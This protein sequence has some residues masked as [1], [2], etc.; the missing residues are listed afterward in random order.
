MSSLAIRQREAAEGVTAPVDILG[1]VAH[2]L[3]QPLSNIE[4]IAYY[5]TLVLPKGDRKIQEQVERIRELVQQT[6]EILSNSV[7]QADCARNSSPVE[8]PLDSRSADPVEGR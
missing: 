5:L 6:N 8:S 4:A 7:R 2:E 1:T 3:R